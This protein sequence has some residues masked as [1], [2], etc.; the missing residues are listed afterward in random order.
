[1]HIFTKYYVQCLNTKI[2][3][4]LVKEKI[5]KQHTYVR[6]SFENF[7]VLFR[8]FFFVSQQI[9]TGIPVQVDLFC[10]ILC[11]LSSEIPSLTLHTLITCLVVNSFHLS[12]LTFVVFSLFFQLRHSY[13]LQQTVCILF[14]G[15]LKPSGY[16]T[17]CHL[18]WQSRKLIFF[19]VESFAMILVQESKL[20]FKIDLLRTLY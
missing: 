18:Y 15:N 13:Q 8:F 19:S 20:I 5:K 7:T 12:C 11:N 14:L 10:N 16:I 6:C 1:M 2:L 17:Y 3:L 4:N 9:F